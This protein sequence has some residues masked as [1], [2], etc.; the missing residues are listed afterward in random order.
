[1]SRIG[2]T[3]RRSEGETRRTKDDAVPRSGRGRRSLK[4]CKV[5]KVERKNVVRSCGLAVLQSKKGV[6]NLCA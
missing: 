2:K 4:V 6:S 5:P 3:G 1:L